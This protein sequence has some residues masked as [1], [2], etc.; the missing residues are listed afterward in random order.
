M[1]IDDH[2]AVIWNRMPAALIPTTRTDNNRLIIFSVM[3]IVIILTTE[4]RSLGIVMLANYYQ[5]IWRE[6][7]GINAGKFRLIFYRFDRSL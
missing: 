1:A 5:F 2:H 4:I 7:H 3:Q 6:Q